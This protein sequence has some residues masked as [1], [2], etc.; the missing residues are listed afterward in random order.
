[1][2]LAFHLAKV[3]CVRQALIA[4]HRRY[5]LLVGHPQ[6][7]AFQHILPRLWAIGY[8]LREQPTNQVA[9]VVPYYHC[10]FGRLD[11]IP[12]VRKDPHFL[13]TNV[14]GL[15]TFQSVSPSCVQS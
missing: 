6:E 7:G 3:L 8:V 15:I 5:T 12:L 1:M 13:P 4:V 14:V 10:Q 11:A 9:G 2:R